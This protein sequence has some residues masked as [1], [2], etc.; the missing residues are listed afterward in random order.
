MATRLPLVPCK[1]GSFVIAIRYKESL[2]AKTSIHS[3]NMNAFFAFVLLALA[4]SDAAP[5]ADRKSAQEILSELESIRDSIDHHVSS[6]KVV[7][8]IRF[9]AVELLTKPPVDPILRTRVEKKFKSYYDR[10]FDFKCGHR[11][12]SVEQWI[13]EEP[14]SEELTTSLNHLKASRSSLEDY[15][16][17]IHEVKNQADRESEVAQTEDDRNFVLLKSIIS[18]HSRLPQLK[19]SLYELELAIVKFQEFV[20]KK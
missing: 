7:G 3:R 18:F 8:A 15:I 14:K 12:E 17:D 20:G 2:N 9:D 13:E 1:W 16:S 11:E 5:S 6:I 10:V 4:L 19:N